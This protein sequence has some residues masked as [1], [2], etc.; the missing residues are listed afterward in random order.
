MVSLRDI[1]KSFFGVSVLEDISIDFNPAQVHVLLGENGAGKSTLMKILSGNY[2]ADKGFITVDGESYPQFTPK[3]AR[4]KGICIIHQELSVVHELSVQENIFMGALPGSKGLVDFASMRKQTQSLLT[5]LDL[6]LDPSQL[7]K[8]LSTAEKQMVEI[9]KALA[10]NARIIIMDE[11][12]T[13]LTNKEIDSLFRVIRLL[14][15]QQKI[16]IYISH[17][18]EE[19]K[20]IGDWVTVLRDGRK[21]VTEKLDRSAPLD[22]QI[23]KLVAHMVGRTITH[24]KILSKI[25]INYSQKP[26]LQA[27]SIFRRDGKVKDI[28]LDVYEGEVFGIAGLV[29]SGRTEFI[30]ALFGVVQ[31]EGQLRFFGE[32]MPLKTPYHAIKKGMALL[33]E[34]RRESGIFQNFPVWQNIAMTKSLKEGGFY[35]MQGLIQK[36]EEQLLAEQFKKVLNIKCAG[37][38]QNITEL[39]GGNQQKTLIARW[40]AAQSRF[41]IFDEP[42]KGIDVGSKREIHM[43]MRQMADDGVGVLI[44]SSELPELLTVADRIGVFYAG[45]LRGILT[46]AEASEEKIMKLAIGQ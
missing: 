35:G 12:T 6:D 23:D 39:S 41:F 45:G 9:A 18:L 2:T 5:A 19:I 38:G 22:G 7:I 1:S 37:V 42:T 16:V 14:L 36:K 34:N 29:G 46:N 33:S 13:S 15:K 17:R 28:S 3:E 25:P 10:L 31:A 30:E 11:P 40:L 44:I 21:I 8:N 20:I 24:E 32:D 43:M 4:E 27:S 26:L